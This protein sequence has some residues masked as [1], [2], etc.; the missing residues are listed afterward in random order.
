MR[1]RVFVARGSAVLLDNLSVY[2]F[3]NSCWEYVSHISELI[4]KLKIFAVYVYTYY[5]YCRCGGIK[6][7]I[8]SYCS[9]VTAIA[10][11][12]FI[13]E[14]NIYFDLKIFFA[15]KF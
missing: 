7:K 12:A 14:K 4:L 11:L 10:I 9:D 3:M 5:I 6:K 1:N 15:L 13:H 2:I 8:L